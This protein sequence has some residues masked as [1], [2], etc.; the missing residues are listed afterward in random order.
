[1]NT[2][3][4]SFLGLALTTVVRAQSPAPVP[5]NAA[6]TPARQ[7]TYLT[8]HARQPAPMPSAGFWVVE[9]Q[10]A[11]NRRTIVRF[12]DDQQREIQ[13]DTLAGKHLRISR[14]AVVDRLNSQLLET[15]AAKSDA[16]L[17]G[18]RPTP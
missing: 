1:M 18:H 12:Y 4:L 9:L 5:A 16:V 14:R 3:L 15:L 8:R 7:G 2:Y 10:P 13:A 17:A 6:S 11:P